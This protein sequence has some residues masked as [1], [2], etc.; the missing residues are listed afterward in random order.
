MYKIRKDILWQKSFKK[1]VERAECVYVN[2]DK[3]QSEGKWILYM[4]DILLKSNINSKTKMSWDIK[5]DK[6]RKEEKNH[7]KLPS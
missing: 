1:D 4:W 2:E 7:R 6:R 5:H 3:R